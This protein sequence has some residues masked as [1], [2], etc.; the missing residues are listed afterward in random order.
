MKRPDQGVLLTL[1]FL[2]GLTGLA[3]E[4]LLVRMVSTQFGTSNFGVIVTITAFMMGLGI[5]SLLGQK[6]LRDVKR[7][8]VAFALLEGMVALFALF[9]PVLSGGSAD[10]FASIGPQLSL[11]E[12]FVLQGGVTILVLM[13]PVMKS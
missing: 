7:P 12:W 10:W 9:M 3:Y 8:L 13:L 1:Y 4:V 5:G 2:S 11:Y 6:L